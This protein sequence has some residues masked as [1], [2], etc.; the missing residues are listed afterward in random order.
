VV[1]AT[2]TR[3]GVRLRRAGAPVAPGVAGAALAP[4]P[5]AVAAGRWLTQLWW[6]VAVV[7]AAR[8]SRARRP[9]VA[10]TVAPPLLEW[11]RRR[12]PVDP[13][14]WVAAVWVD[15]AAYGVGVWRGCVGARSLRPL[16]P[17]FR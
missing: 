9:I 7:L 5:T 4:L 1:A 3:V 10:L 13:L 11:V 16:L 6:P 2:A 15:E 8:E 17:R 14:R 12:P